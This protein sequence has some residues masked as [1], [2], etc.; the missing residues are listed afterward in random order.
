MLRGRLLLEPAAKQV[1]VFGAAA[2][3]S[4]QSADTNCS[5][6]LLAGCIDLA[7]SAC[8]VWGCRRLSRPHAHV[9]AY[10]AN[11]WPAPAF[12]VQVTAVDR[13]EATVAGCAN[14]AS[15]LV[16]NAGLSFAGQRVLPAI[17]PLLTLNALPYELFSQLLG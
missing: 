14:L 3:S 7:V 5:S 8:S 9:H 6:K 2:C 12:G 1:F 11:S 17:V 10:R 4:C 13:S 16:K 15:A